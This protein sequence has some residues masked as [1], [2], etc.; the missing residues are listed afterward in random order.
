MIVHSWNPRDPPWIASQRGLVYALGDLSGGFQWKIPSLIEIILKLRKFVTLFLVGKKKLHLN[1]E[2]SEF[3]AAHGFWCPSP[4][5]RE[6]PLQPGSDCRCGPLAFDDLVLKMFVLP[7]KHTRPEKVAPIFLLIFSAWTFQIRELQHF[8][9]NLRKLN[10]L[11][12]KIFG[13]GWCFFPCP[14]GAFFKFH[15]NFRGCNLS[16]M[17]SSP[18]FT[19]P[20]PKVIGIVFCCC[21]WAVTKDLLVCSFRW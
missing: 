3:F 5:I 4:I 7:F 21:T 17:F 14:F 12:P 1:S 16:L 10:I 6:R 18:F 9:E 2:C 13:M 8:F 20:L 19:S 11:N 15:A